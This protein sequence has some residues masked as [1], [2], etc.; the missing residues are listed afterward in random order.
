MVRLRDPGDTEEVVQEYLLAALRG[1]E[2]CTDRLT[3]RR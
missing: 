2:P 1:A 3:E